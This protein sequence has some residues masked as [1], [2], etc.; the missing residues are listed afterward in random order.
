MY[1]NISLIQRLGD[2][3]SA[4]N[5]L[6]DEFK[7]NY[8]KTEEEFE[9]YIKNKY[10]DLITLDYGNIERLGTYYILTVN[11]TDLINDQKNFTQLFVVK[12]NDF[13]NF[14]LSFQAD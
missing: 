7:E 6:Y 5:L 10:S 3:Q 1:L 11:F 12:E 14:V 8:F 13:N 9:K 4:Y 2:Y